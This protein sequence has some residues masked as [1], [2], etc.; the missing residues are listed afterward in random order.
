MFL[1][2]S[3]SLLVVC[4]SESYG[5]IIMKFPGRAVNGQRNSPFDFALDHRLDPGFSKIGFRE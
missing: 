1:S 2:L 3:M 4:Y 5:E